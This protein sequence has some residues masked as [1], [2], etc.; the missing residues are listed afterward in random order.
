VPGQG[1]AEVVHGWAL[2]NVLRAYVDQWNRERPPRSEASV[3]GD[4]GLGFEA[5][6]TYIAE[7]T[8]RFDRE[9]HGLNSRRVRG[10]IANEFKHVS[11]RQADQVL[12]AI[13]KEYM[14]SN[15]EIAIFP[16]PQWSNERWVKYMQERG[17]V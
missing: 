4:R 17:C 8:R 5:A 16:N 11:L 10:I 9:G 14:L 6:S 12:R 1:E 3:L 15:G 13:G 2:A 7:E